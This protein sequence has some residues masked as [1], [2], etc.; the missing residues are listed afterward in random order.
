MGDATE[1]T[2]S[3]EA[4]SDSVLGGAAEVEAKSDATETKAT[5][6]ETKATA[7]E[8][9]DAKVET[10][11]DDKAAKPA[12]VDDK[13]EPK[14]VE[15]VTRDAKVFGE[16]KA[17]FKKHG[18]TAEQ[19]QALVEFSDAQAKAQAESVKAA[20]EGWVKELTADKDLGGPK[21]AATR[22]SVRGLLRQL[23]TGPALSK[24]VD[25]MGIGNATPL[26]RVLAE[27]ASRTKEDSVKS[28]VVDPATASQNEHE[29]RI[30]RTY[31]NNHKE[32]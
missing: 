30:A 29:R 16:A 9:K 31:G 4:K 25:E 19:A 14:A 13:W 28:T 21:L 26:V 5:G 3:T 32:S 27:L 11:V 10:K 15:G 2:A 8:T 18:F 12:L 7:V 17:L 22:E 23:K 24:W 20:D 6:D 1:T